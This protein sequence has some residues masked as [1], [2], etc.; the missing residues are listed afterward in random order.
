MSDTDSNN[1][2]SVC[3]DAKPHGGKSLLM[4]DWST[5]TQYLRSSNLFYAADLD[6]T[7]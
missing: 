6:S 5:N 1:N 4:L 3:A 2:S 7:F